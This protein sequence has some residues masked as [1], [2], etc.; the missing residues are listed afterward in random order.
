MGQEMFGQ[1]LAAS[2]NTSNEALFNSNAGRFDENND[3]HDSIWKSGSMTDLM[4]IIRDP[5]PTGQVSNEVNGNLMTGSSAHHLS[6]TFDFD[7]TGD[8]AQQLSAGG[9]IPLVPDTSVQ[10]VISDDAD[11]WTSLLDGVNFDEVSC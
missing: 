9:M 6:T 8:P 1:H 4:D 5:V 2:F 10:P 3:S 7:K 11:P